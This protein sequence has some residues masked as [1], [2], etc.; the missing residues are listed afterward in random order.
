MDQD[1]NSADLERPGEVQKFLKIVGTPNGKGAMGV[2]GVEVLGR[3]R[4]I[5]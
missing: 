5:T 3:H 1:S 4:W 2:E